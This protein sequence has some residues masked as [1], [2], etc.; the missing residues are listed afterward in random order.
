MKEILRVLIADDEALIRLDLKEMLLEA[1]HNVVGEA[2]DGEEAVLMTRELLPDLVMMDVKM[3]HIDG[4]LAAKIISEEHL[5]AVVLLTAYS[6]KDI[7]LKAKEAGVLGYLVKPVREEQLFPA[8]EIA[9]SRFEEIEKLGTAIEELK[10][11]LETRK[12]LERAKG[13][14]MTE[15]GLS[16]EAAFRKLQQYSMDKRISVKELA[17]SV[18]AAFSKKNK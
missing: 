4:L 5:A 14:L 10:N 6:Q 15:H 3:P 2:S 7:I 8:I 18:V 13:I 1:G 17:E 16:E 11:D 12:I 9:L